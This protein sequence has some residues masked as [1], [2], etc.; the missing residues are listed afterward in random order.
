MGRFMICTADDDEIKEE[1]MSRACSTY[2][3]EVYAG[4]WW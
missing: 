4:F 1:E 2:K 3:K